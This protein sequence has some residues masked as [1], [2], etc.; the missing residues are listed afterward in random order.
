MNGDKKNKNHITQKMKTEADILGV[1]SRFGFFSIP[2]P[3][4]TGD[5]FYSQQKKANRDAERKVLTL[6]RGVFTTPGKSGKAQDAY[7]SNMIKEEKHTLLR[8]KEVAEKQQKEKLK[9]VETR[10]NRSQS[11]KNYRANFKPGGPQEYKDFYEFPQNR[12]MYKVPVEKTIDKRLKIDKEKR[13]VFME[14]RGIYANPPRVGTSSTPGILFSYFKENPVKLKT[15]KKQVMQRPKSADPKAYKA[16]FKPASLK[17]NENF[18]SDFQI[19][20][21]NEKNVKM[22]LKKSLDIKHSRGE[23]Y[24]YRPPTGSR[25]HD[26]PFKP[27]HLEKTVN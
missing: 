18:E 25:K 21:E 9:M 3:A 12:V 27:N 24:E 26:R 5:Q 22:L 17:K 16:P 4:T 2:Y 20:G 23:K 11:A 1:K 7:F 13:S 10:K 19:F 6:P 14:R 15:F 8:V